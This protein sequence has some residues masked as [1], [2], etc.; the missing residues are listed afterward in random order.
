M[1]LVIAKY[2]EDVSWIKYVKNWN[3]YI[4]NK[5]ENHQGI[6]NL[7]LP[8]IG[9][10]SHSYLTYIV[11]SWDNLDDHICFFQGNP[12]DHAPHCIEQINKFTGDVDFLD[13][14]KGMHPE[15]LPSTDPIHIDPD[16]FKKVHLQVIPQSF[17]SFQPG[18]QFAV[19]KKAIQFYPKEFYLNLIELHLLETLKTPYT[20]ERFWRLIFTQNFLL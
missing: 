8:N 17:V 5:D 3:I 18:A 14:G 9:R 19:S 12:F 7:D 6:F 2:K 16:I 15:S 11:N 20:L 1:T 13:F 10:E 4:I